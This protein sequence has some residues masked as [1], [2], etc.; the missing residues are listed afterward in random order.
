MKI[1]EMEAEAHQTKKQLM[2]R[3]HSNIVKQLTST[4]NTSRSTSTMENPTKLAV[5]Q[6][7]VSHKQ[8]AG[9]ARNKTVTIRKDLSIIDDSMSEE[10][11]SYFSDDICLSCGTRSG[12]CGCPRKT[13][14]NSS[15]KGIVRTNTFHNIFEEKRYNIGGQSSKRITSKSVPTLYGLEVIRE[16]IDLTDGWDIKSNIEIPNENKHIIIIIIPYHLLINFYR[17]NN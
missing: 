1:E 3:V 4:H 11:S 7:K 12:H 2:E 9:S 15:S 17:R 6:Q 16:D 8:N 14:S 10:E 5:Q 13:S